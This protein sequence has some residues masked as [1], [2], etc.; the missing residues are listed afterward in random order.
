LSL[1]GL[2]SLRA[3]T[4]VELAIRNQLGAGRE[5][6]AMGN[7]REA[8]TQAI[9]GRQVAQAKRSKYGAVKVTVDGI[10][11]D[12]KR[13]AQRYH[14]LKLMERAGEIAQLEV[15]PR[16]QL[17]VSANL[18]P[19]GQIMIGDYVADFRYQTKNHIDAIHWH[20]VVEDVKGF[21]TPLYRWKKK[22]V[23]AQYGI[24]IKEI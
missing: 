13:E 8:W 11:F 6:D 3:S 15:Q 18:T 23:E 21:K 5:A 7:Q 12:S 17:R 4:A 1:L 2:Q 14:E 19:L 22:H 9:K 16:F 10:V 24:E 20:T